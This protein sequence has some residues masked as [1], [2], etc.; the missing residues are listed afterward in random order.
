MML[1]KEDEGGTY[2]RASKAT[3]H[4]SVSDFSVLARTS[5]SVSKVAHRSK[6]QADAPMLLLVSYTEDRSRSLKLYATLSSGQA[7]GGKA[8]NSF[9][10]D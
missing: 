10:I 6:L 1:W 3:R 8:A 9:R 4:L 2:S 5:G 7:A